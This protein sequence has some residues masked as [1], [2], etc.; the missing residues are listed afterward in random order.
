MGHKLQ[1]QKEFGKI[2]NQ[3]HH[4]IHH[5][6]L[7]YKRIKTAPIIS[8]PPKN[9]SKKSASKQATSSQQRLGSQSAA[10]ESVASVVKRKN[11]KGGPAVC[12]STKSPPLPVL[13][14][15]YRLVLAKSPSISKIA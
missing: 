12:F 8:H 1:A 14:Q 15:S 4:S 5:T 6:I 10:S 3:L 9:T 13:C 7:P 11:G 2:A